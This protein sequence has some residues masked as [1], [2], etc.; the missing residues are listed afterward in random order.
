M[1]IGEKLETVL[2]KYR[3]WR[4]QRAH[5]PFGDFY[6]AG[7]VALLYNDLPVDSDS[8]VLDVGGFQGDWTA[9][10]SWRYGCRSIVFEPIPGFIR[11]LERRFSRN[12]RIT[13]VGAGLAAHDGAVCM[14][15]A[16][17]GSSAF[18][19]MNGSVV[20]ARMMGVEA[21][22]RE[23][24]LEHVACMKINIE[25]GEFDVLDEMLRLGLND[26]VGCFLIQ[27]HEI[28]PESG[29]HRNKIRASLRD[30]HVSDYDFPFLWERWTHR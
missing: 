8:V 4:Q 5:G 9:E 18:G 10:M 17:D 21:A 6:R 3:L 27:F 11:E 30:S 23:F 16:G 28:A 13:L 2:T 14:R 1:G 7:G 22:F 25:G 29:A 12:Q 20:E 26:R 24:G 19:P 15:V